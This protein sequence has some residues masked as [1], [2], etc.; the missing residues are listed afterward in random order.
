MKDPL[1]PEKRSGVVYQIPCSCGKVYIGETVR[2]LETRMKEH[3]D[4]CRKGLT[5]RSAVAE[6]AWDQQ[7]QIEWKEAMIVDQARGSKE[8]LVKEAL[9]IQMTPSEE[10]INRD[11]GMEIPGCWIAMIR[12]RGAGAA[13]SGRT[14]AS[15]GPVSSTCML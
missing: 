4:A 15:S 13:T 3:Q 8:L 10:R 7:H 9:H 14:P 2:R 11:G 5:E 6:H 12:S 1:P